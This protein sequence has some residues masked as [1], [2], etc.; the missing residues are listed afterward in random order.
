MAV[1][2]LKYSV[3]LILLLIVIAVVVVRLSE[4]DSDAVAIPELHPDSIPARLSSDAKQ[5][6]KEL[7]AARKKLA[8]LK[9]RGPY[10]V[11]DTHA[12]MLYY[13]TEDSVILAARCSTGSGGELVDSATGQRW[14]FDTPRG[15]FK[16][17]NKLTE[18]WWRKP[19]WA[20]IEENEPIPKREEERFDP[21]VMGDYALGFGDG[22]FIHG[23]IY[24]R[25][26][27]IN[28]THGCVRVGSDDLD[29]LYKRTPI[30]TMVYIF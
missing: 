18:P 10:I 2:L 6:K 1:K 29:K 25:L 28:V 5:A 9:P 12:N 19:D 15:V 3:G 27:G 16:I 4:P 20:F 30:G 8:G 23:T 21:N 24:E 22:F 14:I 17:K 11:I 26:L 13:R 7:A